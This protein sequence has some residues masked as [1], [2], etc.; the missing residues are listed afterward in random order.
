[1][2][3]S[4]SVQIYLVVQEQ[5][6]S[7]KVLEA[8]QDKEAASQVIKLDEVGSMFGKLSLQETTLHFYGG[9]NE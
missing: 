8:F 6:G 3:G 4:K 5:E 2:I 1:L 9:V 7:I